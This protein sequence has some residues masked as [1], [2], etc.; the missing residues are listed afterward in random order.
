MRLPTTATAPFC[1]PEVQGTIAVPAGLSVLQKFFRFAGP[2]L[3]VSVGY[4][5]PGNWATDIEAGSRYGYALLFVV[6]ASSL[7]AIVL[8][9]L[10]AR[11]GIASGRDL[12]QLARDRYSPAASRT[13]WLLAEIA[14]VACDIAEVLGSA[15]A[16]KLLF[17]LPLWIGVLLT[18]LDTV[19]V[20]GLASRGFRRIEA[21][22]LAL[23][24]TIAACF[25]VQLVIAQP[26]L[27][28]I[29]PGLVPDPAKLADPHALYLA[30][31]I[32]GAT[33]MPHNLYLHSSIVQTRI[34][35]PTVTARRQAIRFSTADIVGSL[36]LAS[37][38]NAAIL[39]LAAATFHASGN[40]H[41]ADIEDAWR[42]L[43]PLTG[44]AIAAPLFAI[45]L[46]A[47]GQSATFTGTIAGQVI[48]EGFLHLRIP[49]WQR[50]FITRGLA[51]VPALAG[52]LWLGEHAVGRML[53]MT[54]VVLSAQLPFAIY[55]LVRFTGDRSIMGDFVSPLWLRLLAWLLF[56]VIAAANV[57]ML[58]GFMS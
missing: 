54:Q 24:A 5:D 22:I 55:P 3:L 27:A 33:I 31:G 14:I 10:A 36:L 19:F 4:M 1:P 9:T 43:E 29:L 20:L 44:A 12:A 49:C 16:I 42:L 25:V 17:G 7:A 56:A 8:Q 23:V 21:I 48:L 13:L 47:S 15:L 51:L 38:V 11:L 28:A 6:V 53:V 50:R 52:V 39:I 40:T 41:I 18:A 37:M 58:V 34:V 35:A 2:G 30:I 46:F 26:S 32:L 57:W 45:A